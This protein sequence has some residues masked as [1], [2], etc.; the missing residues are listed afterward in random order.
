M[1]YSILLYY[2][3]GGHAQALLECLAEALLGS[4]QRVYIYIYIYI[5]Y[6]DHIVLNYNIAYYIVVY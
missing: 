6:V 3:L 4:A 5:Y 1:F 2:I